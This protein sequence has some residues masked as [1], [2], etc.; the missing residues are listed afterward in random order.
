[1]YMKDSKEKNNDKNVE[2]ATTEGSTDNA[3]Y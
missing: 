1:M 2:Q 3:K